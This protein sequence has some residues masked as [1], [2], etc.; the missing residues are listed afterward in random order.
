M[1][2]L[3][4][5]AHPQSG[6]T[7]QQQAHIVTGLG[8]NVMT[9]MLVEGHRVVKRTDRRIRRKLFRFLLSSFVEAEVLV[10]QHFW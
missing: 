10:L 5:E 4:L 1:G 3:R 2:R 9:F 7:A 6:A 8:Q